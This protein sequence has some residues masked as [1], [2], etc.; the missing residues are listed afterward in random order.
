MCFL[1]ISNEIF[2]INMHFV[3]S[4]YLYENSNFVGNQKV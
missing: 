1:E 4:F 2:E 3:F